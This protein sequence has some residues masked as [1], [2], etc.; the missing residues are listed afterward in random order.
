M[1]KNW[2]VKDFAIAINNAETK[3]E[4]IADA[5]RRFPLTANLIS[6]I[7]ATSAKESF[8][9]FTSAIPEWL[10]MR[11]VE[12]VLK[13]G[14]SVSE[15]APEEEEVVAEEKPKR[16]RGRKAKVEEP[17]EEVEA[18]EEEEEVPAPK[19]AKAKKAKAEKEEKPAKKAK[20]A[21]KVEE[22]EEDEDDDSDWEI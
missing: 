1:A 19:K 21:P 15:E 4:A 9:E 5:G 7:M 2:N 11:K 13:D 17:A 10:T 20:K 22:P 12:S 3:K 6:S 14:V 16:G 8:I 18:E